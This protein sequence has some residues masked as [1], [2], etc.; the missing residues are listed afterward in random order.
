MAA[1]ANLVAFL[2]PAGMDWK[3][4]LVWRIVP[5]FE[6]EE[7]RTSL[8]VPESLYGCGARPEIDRVTNDSTELR[9]SM[10]EEVYASFRDVI[11][12][13]D[14]QVDPSIDFYNAHSAEDRIEVLLQ[15]LLELS[16]HPGKTICNNLLTVML[17]NLEVSH[18][19]L[20][21]FRSVQLNKE[22]CRAQVK[23]K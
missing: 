19:F 22:H 23:N 14:L 7:S 8:T 17:D 13:E 5:K 4:I 16:R 1:H 15:A 11:C 10:N 18:Y 21:T 3:P 6:R 12:P 9:N 2:L 20:C